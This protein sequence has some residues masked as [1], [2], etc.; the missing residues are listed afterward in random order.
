MVKYL[1]IIKYT[2]IKKKLVNYFLNY[3]EINFIIILKI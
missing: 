1:N 2:I 3:I